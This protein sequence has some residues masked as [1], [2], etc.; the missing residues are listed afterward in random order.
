MLPAKLTRKVGLSILSVSPPDNTENAC[1][2]K[3]TT[4]RTHRRLL[5]GTAAL[6]LLASAC[7]D[8]KAEAGGDGDGGGSAETEL[9]IVG[10]AIPE[11]ANKA[12][13]EE[14]VKTPAGEGVRFKTSYGASGVELWSFTRASLADVLEIRLRD[15]LREERGGTYGVSVGAGYSR[16]PWENY[17]VTLA[18]GAA[19]DSL[20]ALADAA[21]AEIETLQNEPPTLESVQHVQEIQRRELEQGLRQN[22]YW[23][24][25]L[26]GRLLTGEPPISPARQ[27]ELI[28]AL[29][30][31]AISEAARQYLSLQRYVRVSLF[32]EDWN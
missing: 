11:A 25:N 3:G 17:S 7:G 31:E 13:A 24:A 23:L 4:M 29:T 6:F 30:P 22:S 28:D 1:G 2:Q 26:S 8:D 20:D 19:P 5:A 12:I 14:F 16:T 27:R 9:S 21:L 10:F 18:F 15:E 32:P